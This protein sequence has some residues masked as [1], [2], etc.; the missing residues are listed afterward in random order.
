M[1]DIVYIVFGR[2][3]DMVNDN[4]KMSLCIRVFVYLFVLLFFPNFVVRFGLD[5]LV[6]NYWGESWKI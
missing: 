5:D 1:G 3:V 4:G 2:C 6:M